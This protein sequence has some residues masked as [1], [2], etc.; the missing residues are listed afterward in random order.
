MLLGLLGLA[1][2][3]LLICVLGCAGL[4]PAFFLCYGFYLALDA[5]WNDRQRNQP[6]PW[7]QIPVSWAVNCWD[8]LRRMVGREKENSVLGC[9]VTGCLIL[10][11]LFL[12]LFTTCVLDGVPTCNYYQPLSAH[13]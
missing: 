6:W 10:L 8:M 1:V 5:A 2:S 3:V 11:S 7:Y 4:P 13:R 12:L 9:F